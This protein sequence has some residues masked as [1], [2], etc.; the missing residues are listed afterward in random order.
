MKPTEGSRKVVIEGYEIDV[1]SVKAA[2]YAPLAS[3]ASL[4]RARLHDTP[5]DL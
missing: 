1:G 2:S 4:L 5:F 3:A